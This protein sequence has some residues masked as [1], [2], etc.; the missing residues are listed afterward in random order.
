M[1]AIERNIR[2]RDHLTAIILDKPIHEVAPKQLSAAQAQDALLGWVYKQPG[3]PQADDCVYWAKRVG[4]EL[5]QEAIA[6]LMGRHGLQGLPPTLDTFKS[7]WAG[8]WGRFVRYAAAAV[9]FGLDPAWAWDVRDDVDWLQPYIPEQ[10]TRKPIEELR[11]RWLL[12]HPE[13]DSLFTVDSWGAAERVLESGD[14]VDDV[15][16]IEFFETKFYAEKTGDKL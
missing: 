12:S 16:G 11:T 10:I 5:G 7:A 3:M 15:T 9:Y 8:S 4:K 2:A 14:G 1:S 6:T 13:S